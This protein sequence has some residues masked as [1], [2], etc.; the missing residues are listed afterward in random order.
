MANVAVELRQ[1]FTSFIAAK[2]FIERIRLLFAIVATVYLATFVVGAISASFT[3]NQT[4]W[5]RFDAMWLHL[6]AL[7]VLQAKAAGS[8][9]FESASPR[10]PAFSY[11]VYLVGASASSPIFLS[12]LYQIV[13]FAWA[14]YA[15]FFVARRFSAPAV[16]VVT[17]A[18]LFFGTLFSQVIIYGFIDLNLNTQALFFYSA[19]VFFA[20][21]FGADKSLTSSMHLGA[22]A[23]L[24]LIARPTF[25]P[26]LIPVGLCLLYHFRSEL[27][28]RDWF[29]RAGAG[30]VVACALILVALGPISGSIF[31]YYSGNY[32]VFHPMGPFGSLAG[33]GDV[34]IS[35]RVGVVQTMIA[36]GIIGFMVLVAIASHFGRPRLSESQKGLIDRFLKID[37]S[38]GLVLALSVIA[39]LSVVAVLSLTASGNPKTYIP[40]LVL[41]PLAAL[42][43]VIIKSQWFRLAIQ[44]GL[45]AVSVPWI[46][47]NNY[48]LNLRLDRSLAAYNES[49]RTLEAFSAQ[50]CRA[51]ADQRQCVIGG[52]D[53]NAFGPVTLETIAT[54]RLGLPMDARRNIARAEHLG[55]DPG[56]SF[57]PS[58]LETMPRAQFQNEFQSALQDY[59]A[60]VDVFFVPDVEAW[61][62]GEPASREIVKAMLDAAR[63]TLMS[64]L[65]L[66]EVES[67]DFTHRD[68]PWEA[69]ARPELNLCVQAQTAAV[70]QQP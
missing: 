29:A 6:H 22:A 36:C 44:A 47:D 19:V 65:G 58:L 9:M 62:D 18:F 10:S 42:A 61:P 41:F 68:I 24:F 33:F 8:G 55:F 25:A 57:D 34:V 7:D 16:T 43:L 4:F 21:A 11:F 45:V 46:A 3:Y 67:F 27:R 52:F 59:L 15:F 39:P 31:S 38:S 66:C 64:D 48:M 60:G 32:D 1:G 56:W 26:F 53:T 69:W 13:C 23:A 63:P 30:L 12:V 17:G 70:E 35:D 14:V 20:M 49:Q 37:R 50:I 54:T 28:D 2:T 51:A 40:A 5:P